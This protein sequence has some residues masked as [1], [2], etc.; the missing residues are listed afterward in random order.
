[1]I[2]AGS[3]FTLALRS[4]GTVWAFGTNWN[5]IVPGNA[6]ASSP[7]PAQVRALPGLRRSRSNRIA[8]MRETAKGEFGYGVIHGN[9]KPT[10]A[11]RELSESETA[12]LSERVMSQLSPEARTR[13]LE[14]KWNGNLVRVSESAVEVAGAR[15]NFEGSVIDIDLGWTVA[16]I[17][18]PAGSELKAAAKPASSTSAA[19]KARAAEKLAVGASI[20]A[21]SPAAVVSPY[22][23]SAGQTHGLAAASQ[24]NSLRGR[25]Q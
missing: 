25:Q 12:G 24:W 1:M 4:D 16:L 10:A 13:A 19:S 2:A 5:E 20:T 23:I 14:D 21:V 3:L 8:A 9:V 18:A 11:P 15:Y 7:K 6:G 22:T 17:A